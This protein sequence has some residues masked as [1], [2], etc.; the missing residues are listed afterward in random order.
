[1]CSSWIFSDSGKCHLMVATVRPGH[2]TKLPALM[3]LIYVAFVGKPVAACKYRIF[4]VVEGNSYA[5]ELGGL[6]ESCLYWKL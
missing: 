3:A 6:L 4:C 5:L 1:M 2:L